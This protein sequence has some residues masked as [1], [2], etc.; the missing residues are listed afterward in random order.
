[1]S[2]CF[3]ESGGCASAVGWNYCYLGAS[4]LP[5]N[6]PTGLDNEFMQATNFYVAI[7]QKPLFAPQFPPE[8]EIVPT[9]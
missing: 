2:A 3:H 9:A 5:L 6:R 7:P 4:F 1:M 8:P